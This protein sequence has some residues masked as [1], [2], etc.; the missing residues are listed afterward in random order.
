MSSPSPQYRTQLAI[1]QVAFSCLVS[2]IPFIPEC[3][4]S[5]CVFR[6]I[7]ILEGSRPVIL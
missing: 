2:V 7:D 6:G 4:L 1:T 3:F 5:L